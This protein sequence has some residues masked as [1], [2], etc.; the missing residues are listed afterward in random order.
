M[1][2]LKQLRGLVIAFI[3]GM[4]LSQLSVG[5]KI[6]IAIPLILLWLIN[7]DDAAIE[8]NERKHDYPVR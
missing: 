4:S 8:R 6:C 7:Y 5:A 1:R 2:K 3:G